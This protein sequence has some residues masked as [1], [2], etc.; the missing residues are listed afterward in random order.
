[1][2]IKRWE[3]QWI[4]DCGR[5]QELLEPGFSFLTSLR[6]KLRASHSHKSFPREL[7]VIPL[8][9]SKPHSFHLGMLSVRQVFTETKSATPSC[10]STHSVP[11]SRSLGPGYLS[12]PPLPNS[13]FGTLLDVAMRRRRTSFQSMNDSSAAALAYAHRHTRY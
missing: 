5:I 12:G 9:I 4:L 11:T 1:M 10:S 2:I 3:Y 6:L 7:W 13:L 8:C